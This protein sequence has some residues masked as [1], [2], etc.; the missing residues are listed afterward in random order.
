MVKV[1]YREHKTLGSKKDMKP[2]IYLNSLC[3][4]VTKVKC[5]FVQALYRPYAQ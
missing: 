4:F 3:L 1:S 2:E 5:T